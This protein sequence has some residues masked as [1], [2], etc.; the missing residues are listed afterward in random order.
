MIYRRAAPKPKAALAAQE[1]AHEFFKGS[2]TYHLLVARDAI[3]EILEAR[4]N[5]AWDAWTS[6][7]KPRK[8]A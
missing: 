4:Q 3:D 6:N 1:V 5:A 8:S 2:S 7:A